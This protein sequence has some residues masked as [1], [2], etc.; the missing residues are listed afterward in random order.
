VILGRIGVESQRGEAGI[1]D[2]PRPGAAMMVSWL[3]V[4]DFHFSGGDSYNRDRVLGALVHSV[5]AFREEG[6]QPDLVFATGDVAYSGQ[7]TEYQDATK[8]FDLLLAAARV[9]KRH[10]YVIP[11]NH[12]VDRTQGAG[13]ARTLG[14]REEADT[15]FASSIPKNH[16]TQKQRA[17]Q[18]WYDH[19]FDGIRKF[20]HDSTCGPVEDVNIRGVK[21]GIL[22]L[23]SALFCQGDDDHAKLWIGRRCLEPAIVDLLDRSAALNI[24]LV[25]HPLDWL[26]HAELV[27]V[28][29]ELQSQVDLILRGHLHTPD[30]VDVIAGAMGETLHMAAGASYQT[31]QFPNRAFYASLENDQVDVFPIR[32]EDEPRGRW[33]LD[34]GIFS[35]PSYTKAFPIRRLSKLRIAAE[36]NREDIQ[37]IALLARAVFTNEQLKILEKLSKD[38]SYT[39]DT[40]NT[41]YY[42]GFKDNIVRLR[43]AGFIE[44]KKDKG[45]RVL[46]QAGGTQDARA[47]FQVTGAGKRFLALLERLPPAPPE[48]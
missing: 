41:V 38:E 10:L 4:S 26:H 24:A 14:S 37:T 1:D 27:N 8:F 5:K 25:H 35:T 11:G 42:N 45:L 30:V 13:L 46:E 47:Y 12:D 7:S 18:Q 19:Y 44:N 39:T 48:G 6:K 29:T 43:G 22:P 28:K 34:T 2:I 15:Y 21:I 16:I 9:D 36:Q 33:T 20:P 40:A 32:Y 31:T 17:F 3:H 23:N